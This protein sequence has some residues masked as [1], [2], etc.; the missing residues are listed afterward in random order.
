MKAL[1]LHYRQSPSGQLAVARYCISQAIQYLLRHCAEPENLSAAQV[2]A[3]LFLKHSRSSAHTMGGLAK[4]MA[5]SY[6]TISA[7]VDALE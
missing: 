7:M 2:Q 1:N 5:L 6:P 3:L 4:G